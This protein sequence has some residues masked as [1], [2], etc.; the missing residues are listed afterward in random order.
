MKNQISNRKSTI[1]HLMAA[2][3]LLGA[4]TCF[5]APTAWAGSHIVYVPPPNGTDDTTNIQAAFDT[6]V[7][8]GKNCTLQ[9]AAG[10]YHTSQVAV[11]GFVGTFRG[12]GKDETIIKTLDRTLQVAP[13][14]F[15][16]NP[17][18]P[19][20]GSNPWPSIFAFVGGD[21][22]ISDLSFLST[23]NVST[24]GWTWTGLGITVYE[25][26][27]AFVVVGPVVPGQDYTEANA[28]LYRVHIEGV[29]QEGTLFGYDP[30]SAIYYEGLFGAP[31]GQ[32]LP[33]RGRF[34][35]H[36]SEFGHVAGGTNLY[37]LYDSRA[38]ITRNRFADTFEGMDIGVVTNTTYEY[39]DNEVLNSSAWGLNL[40]GSFDS[41]SL[42][43]RNNVIT[44]TGIGLF[45]DDSVTFTGHVEC[46]LLRNSVED[47]ADVGIYLGPGTR[48][49]LV[50]LKTCEDTV[51]NLGTNNKIIG[52]K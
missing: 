32:T 51:L 13:L 40:N 14:N 41:S 46:D 30:I 19:E 37:N 48:D 47:V 27:H 20:S 38:S 24:T 35:A 22:V 52:C 26:A 8:Y 5:T 3:L 4:F 50:V 45:L 42:V 31:Y 49:C 39:A 25:L 17:P 2:W 21:I 34:D 1:T 15:F 33:L 23:P 28:A 11:I 10:T 29:E 44:G 36:D 6:C 16:E 43:V 7:A 9:L 12:V 18:T